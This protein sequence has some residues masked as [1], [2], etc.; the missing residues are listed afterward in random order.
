[1]PELNRLKLAQYWAAGCGGCDV[2]VLELHEKILEL[3]QHV[4]LVFWPI[5][6][7]A[8]VEDVE[9]MP[10]GSV[11]L[12]LVNGSMRNT[13]NI[14]MA[15]LLRRKARILVAFGSCA[16]LGGIPALA[17]LSSRR[18]LLR[19]VYRDSASTSNPDGVAPAESHHTPHGELELPALLPW[20]QALDQVVPV[21]YAIPGCPPDPGKVWE[22]LQAVTAGQLPPPG[23]VLGA[24]DVALCDECPRT[25]GE[26]EITAFRRLSDFT[27]DPQQCLLEQGVV[28]CGPV[29]RAGCG[30]SCVAANMPCRG[31]YG[32]PPGVTDQ[33]A[34]L[35]SAVAS[36][37]ASD[38]PAEVERIVA[39]VEDPAG[40]FYRFS[41]ASALLP[42]AQ[43]RE[44]R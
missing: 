16:H 41:L 8:K 4:E 32:P 25:K 27:P 28:C 1:V 33:G 40:T 6:L 43:Q 19:Q 35:L 11:D 12:A 42:G 24:R 37:I 7:D 17:N 10:D 38:D 23:T 15:R 31:C 29:T 20:A 14:H 18:D 22:V 2:A 26:K 5:A 34:K 39:G 21:D 9:A 36:V 44:L 13:E 3:V 30:A